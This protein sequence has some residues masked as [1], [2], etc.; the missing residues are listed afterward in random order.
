MTKEQFIGELKTALAH[1]LP[2]S[3]ITEQI[4]YYE[5]HFMEETKK[6]LSEEEVAEKLGEPQ[7]VAKTLVTAYALKET[8]NR[9]DD[10]YYFGEEKGFHGTYRKEG[11]WDLRLGS[12]KLNSWYGNTIL[13]FVVIIL[14]MLYEALFK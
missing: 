14:I 4:E 10:T 1:K 5:N 2:A 11:G 9:D 12:F 7:A 3:E 6:G 13:C 8:G